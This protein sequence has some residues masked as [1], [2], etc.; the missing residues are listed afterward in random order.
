M[1]KNIKYGHFRK[2]IKLLIQTGRS[3]IVLAFIAMLTMTVMN[4]L[5][6]GL[7]QFIIDDGIVK[8]RISILIKYCSVYIGLMLSVRVIDVI[9]ENYYGKLR[10]EVSS[11]LKAMFYH[12]IN[13]VSGQYLSKQETGN[14]LRILDNDIYQVESFGIDLIFDLITNIITAIIVVIILAKQ[15]VFLLGFAI[16]IQMSM[17]GINSFLSKSIT[18]NIKEVRDISGAQSNLQE[19]FVSNLKNIIIAN[20][21]DFVSG[22]LTRKQEKYVEKSER[23]NF[24]IA[25]QSSIA[26]G[27]NSLGIIMTYLFGGMLIIYTN[28]SIGE[29]I[30]FLQYTTLLISPCMFLISYNLKIRQISVSLGKIYDELEKITTSN[31]DTGK[32]NCNE[33]INTIEFESVSFSYENIGII[34]NLTFL[35]KSGEITALIGESGCGKSTIVNLIY[36]LWDADAGKILINGK[37]IGNYEICSLRNR[38]CVIGQEVLILDDSIVDNVLLEDREKMK[39]EKFDEICTILN[40]DKLVTNRERESVGE[41]GK[42]IS[43][44]QKQKVAIARALLRECDVFIF[45]E[46][47]SALDNISQ[48]KVLSGIM[49]YLENK[50]VL[51]IAHRMETIKNADK[52][53]VMEK[54]KIVEEGKH[55]EL[56]E[57]DGVYSKMLHINKDI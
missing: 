50:I 57:K 35:L 49:P 45:D 3:Q 38:I 15:N 40:I 56:L 14:V 13:R 17:F 21:G 11:Q 41:N 53:L 16:V 25:L 47:T 29:L 42:N 46:A 39:I 27:I 54:G 37:E 43:G 10:L 34:N 19:Q 55:N 12:G 26:N 30:S 51:I 18:E 4:L 28:M 22:I 20:I 31:H 7:L 32:L 24:L 52:I 1:K 8:K 48:Q 5:L 33:K 23:V 6:P 2:Y 36:R 9:L 44:G